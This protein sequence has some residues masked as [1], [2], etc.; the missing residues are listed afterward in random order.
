MAVAKL[1]RLPWP[2]CELTF[3]DVFYRQGFPRGEDLMSSWKSHG[4]WGHYRVGLQFDWKKK[5]HL[6]QAEKKINFKVHTK[7]W[8]LQICL[9]KKNLNLLAYL[10]LAEYAEG[11]DESVG[12]NKEKK[13][14]SL[15]LC[16]LLVSVLQSVCPHIWRTS[17]PCHQALSGLTHVSEGVKGASHGARI[18][19]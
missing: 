4:P 5:K 16:C 19:R 2:P 11:E 9:K 10:H 13:T 6:K 1:S 15:R 14:K 18:R 17:L 12:N 3:T 8:S 7:T